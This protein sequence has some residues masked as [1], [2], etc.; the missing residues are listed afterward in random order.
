MGTERKFYKIP[1]NMQNKLV[2]VSFV[3]RYR[4]ADENLYGNTNK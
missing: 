3:Y 2:K 4:G 1:E